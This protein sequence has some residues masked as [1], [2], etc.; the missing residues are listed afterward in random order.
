MLRNLT[1][2]APL[3]FFIFISA[4]QAQAAPKASDAARTVPQTLIKKVPLPQLHLEESILR[5]TDPLQGE[6]ISD[7]SLK[8]YVRQ[9]PYYFD[10][11]GRLLPP[12][13]SYI[14]EKNLRLIITDTYN[15]RVI[16]VDRYRNILWQYGRTGIPGTGE[17]YLHY[18]SFAEPQ[19]DGEILV[20]DLANDRVIRVKDARERWQYGTTLVQGDD[21]NQLFLAETATCLADGTVLITD[22]SNHRAA[23]VN[24]RK[25]V[26][27][28]YGKGFK[29]TRANELD[30]PQ[31]SA[32]ASGGK[33]LI[34]DT[35]NHRVILVD[36]KKNILWQYGK[37]HQAGSQKNELNLPNM[38][39]EL[40]NGNILIVDSGNH[41][42]IEVDRKGKILWQYG[43][44]GKEGSGFNELFWPYNAYRLFNGNTLITDSDNNRI[45][46][47]DPYRRIVWQYGKTGKKGW[48]FNQLDAPYD[49]HIVF[50][51]R[52]EASR[53]AFT[54]E[55]GT[56]YKLQEFET[57]F[58]G[59]LL[60]AFSLL[61]VGRGATLD[62]LT[63]PPLAMDRLKEI[64]AGPLSFEWEFYV[65]TP[66][67]KEHLASET[68]WELPL[69]TSG[70]AL[71]IEKLLSW[72]L[73]S[74]KLALGLGDCDS[75]IPDKIPFYLSFNISVQPSSLEERLLLSSLQ[76]KKLIK[77]ARKFYLPPPVPLR[78][79]LLLAAAQEETR[80]RKP[81]EKLTGEVGQIAFSWRVSQ[82][83]EPFLDFTGYTYHQA[84]SLPAA[85]KK[86]KAAKPVARKKTAPK[87]PAKKEEKAVLFAPPK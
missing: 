42:V 24:D 71:P 7:F 23:I 54:L 19:E 11:R 43:K 64:I 61:S 75:S 30:S 81:L 28:Q 70:G 52:E 17:G 36:R 86:K 31:G 78:P 15:H 29:G 16:E 8:T 74:R 76:L 5:A 14:A 25:K 59:E 69:I 37:T 18:P 49:A 35:G 33:I 26:V 66:D 83:K 67:L 58:S 47:A 34:S 50:Q 39:T 48:G 21:D 13:S 1:L 44:T 32:E 79:G 53:S 72:K 85:E 9:D 4:S 82:R 56:F 55:S 20:T 38:A 27:W 68:L 40:F 65:R 73:S 2:L 51:H 10:E 84:R 63:P 87:K 57:S 60:P 41:R 3:L 77:E 22:T 12:P 45:I 62:R 6:I 46:E 80:L